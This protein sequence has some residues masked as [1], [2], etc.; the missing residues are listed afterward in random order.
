MLLK[1]I[2]FRSFALLFIFNLQQYAFAQKK[3]TPFAN[4]LLKKYADTNIAFYRI[5]KPYYAAVWPR[6]IPASIKLVRQL[7]EQTAIIEIN[8]SVLFDSLN[9]KITIAPARD[10]W[11][12]SPVLE[13]NSKMN[14]SSLQSFI[15]V[16]TNIDSLLGT[17]QKIQPAIAIL[18]VYQPSN[19]IVVKC[20][21]RQI[22]EQLLLL[23]QIIFIDAL[24]IPQ[25]E[26]GIIGYNRSFHGLSAVDYLIPTANGKNIVVG[27]KEQKMQEVD[28]DIYKRVLPSQIAAN[29]IDNHATVIASIIGGSGNSFYDGRGIANRCSFFSS[30]FA[31]L[32]ADDTSVLNTNKV[33]VQNHSYGTVVQQFYGAEAL[34]YD[35]HG[36]QN[37]NRVHVFSSGNRGTTAATDGKYASIAGYANLTGNFK[38]AKNI[39]TV[40]AI[41]NKGNIPTESSAGPLYDGRVAPQLIAL[42]PNGTSDAAAVV[43]GTIAVIQ[44][45]YAD[46]NSLALPPASLTKAIL[47]NTAD[48]VHSPGIDYK[49]GYGQL[50][51]YEAIRAIQ[52]RKYDG[53]SLA[54]SQSW[55]KVITVPPNSAKIKITLAWTDTAATVNNSRALVNDLDLELLQI[56]SGEVYKPWVLNA[57]PQIDSLKKQGTRKR[58]SL[59]T[60]EQLSIELP[61][62]GTYNIKVIG[63]TV[64]VSNMA[65]HVAYSVDTLNTFSFINPQ[66]SSDVNRIENANLDVIWRTFVADTNQAGS[67]YI[68]YNNGVSWQ[69]VQ[70]GIKLFKNKT[71]WPIKDTSSTALFKM[72]TPFG[73]FLSRSFVI[74]TVN[75]PQVDFNCT[76]SLRLSWNKHIY[77][78]GYKVWGLTTDSAYLQPLLAVTD[79]FA[80]LKRSLYPQIVFAV[81]PLLS[82]N[83]PASRSIAFDINFQGVQCFYKTLN[84]NLLDGN[85]LD[86]ILELS[87]PE[88]V[89]SVFFEQVTATGQP[90]QIYGGLKVTANI[91][92]YRQLVNRLPGGTIYLRARIKSKNGQSVFTN[93]VSV[94]SSGQQNILFYP[95]PANRNNTINYVLRQGIPASGSLLLFDISGR[96]LKSYASLPNKLNLSGLARGIIIY[97]LLNNDN[98]L[99]E[100]GKLFIW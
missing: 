56:S 17:V 14:S 99:V 65:F 12:L 96:L 47:Y 3:A 93:I 59:N 54:Q 43:S 32:F 84:Y 20:S 37:K 68:S 30:S 85:Q 77:A 74:S 79:T 26:T 55:T 63:T 15:L 34:S 33:T 42:G 83:L 90:V 18:S 46:N 73:D 81:E 87:A 27:V 60:A 2:L 78:T 50:N 88:Y 66:H 61:S 94:L 44:Q 29:T 97:K 11:K 16:G 9:Q 7:D 21:A 57:F 70:S 72:Q 28:L 25:I 40:G 86:I 92:I 35:L 67:L 10:S 45:V 52:Q 6:A 39:I 75:R 100:T 41:D 24:E 91:A 5:N 71:Q 19:A 49:T 98:R 82:N 31:N 4:A 13:K 36:W 1:K 62:A 64:S 76:D 53:G 51:S 69:L 38:M 58:D 48:D 80:V 8:N 23:Q 22:K 95:N 89:D